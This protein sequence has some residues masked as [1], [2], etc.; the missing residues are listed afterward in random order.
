VRQATRQDHEAFCRREGW[1]VVRNARG[2]TVSHHLTLELGLPSGEILRT[3]ISHPVN[4]TTYGP[5]MWSHILRAQ[6]EVS[7]AQFWACV[8]HKIAPDRGDALSAPARA[9]PAA[10]VFQLINTVGVPE[11]E[12]MR[13]TREQAIARLND[14]WANPPER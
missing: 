6:L 5:S 3:R 2:G 11:H 13:M 4:R 12:V 14:H 7:E 10:V 8:D 1:A 9:I